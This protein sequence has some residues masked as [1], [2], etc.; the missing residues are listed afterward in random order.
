MGGGGTCL[1]LRCL[2]RYRRGWSF[3]AGEG[4]GSFQLL[5]AAMS[6][7][8]HS[9]RAPRCQKA[10]EEDTCTLSCHYLHEGAFR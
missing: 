8:R 3:G 10:E 6:V 5:N 2:C 1:T 4:G 7:W 9:G